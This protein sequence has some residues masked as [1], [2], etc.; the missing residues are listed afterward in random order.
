MPAKKKATKR[1]VEIFSAG[2]RACKTT[3][4]LVKRLACESCEVK[5]LDMR[6]AAVS[7][8][9]KRLGIQRVPAVVING[10]LAECCS[11]S[12]VDRA[13]LKEAGLGVRLT[14]E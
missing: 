5:V 3:I 12:G 11:V 8:R 6:K 10:K 9:A 7:A 13:T 1:Q 14:S 4:E 2:C